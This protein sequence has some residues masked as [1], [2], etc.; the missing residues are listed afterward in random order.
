MEEDGSLTPGS[1]IFW[2]HFYNDEEGRLIEKEVHHRRS[3]EIKEGGGLL[4]HYEWFMEYERY[5]PILIQ[6]LER[7]LKAPATTNVSVLHVLHVGCGNSDFCDHFSSAMSLST[8]FSSM[9]CCILNTDIC[10]NIISRLSSAFPERLYAV[11]NCCKLH[12]SKEVEP[13]DTENSVSME[14]EGA[15]KEFTAS[16]Y[17][18]QRT[19]N[20]RTDLL[21]MDSTVH[22]IFD[23]GTMDALLS[24]FPGQ[25]NPNVLAYAEESIRV[26]TLG[27]IWYIISINAVDI[28]DSYVLAVCSEDDKSFRRVH[29]SSIELTSHET[30]LIRVETLGSRYLCY[31]YVVVGKEEDE[32]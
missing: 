14:P 11:G 12:S 22:L 2:D 24:A 5:G 32:E 26:L 28:V 30:N 31:A 17:N 23:K 20:G 18:S 4:N 3:V 27:S 29:H 10:E 1:K 8:V 16:W 19:S 15:T 9:K 6:V 25:Y 21:V 7:E 13:E